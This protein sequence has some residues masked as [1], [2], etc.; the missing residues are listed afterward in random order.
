[1]PK[2][3]SGRDPGDMHEEEIV[4]W[5]RYAQVW[6]KEVEQKLLAVATKNVALFD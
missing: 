2:T 3:L 4:E 1:M 5:L 6:S